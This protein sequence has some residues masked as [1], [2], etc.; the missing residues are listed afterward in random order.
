MPC[1]RAR[2][3]RSHDF[4]PECKNLAG[5]GSQP[6]CNVGDFLLTIP[7][8]SAAARSTASPC[9]ARRTEVVPLHFSLCRTP[10]LVTPVTSS[11][12]IRGAGFLLSRIDG[13]R[14]KVVYVDGNHR[15]GCNLLDWLRAGPPRRRP[16]VTQRYRCLS[17]GTWNQGGTR[18]DEL[19]SPVSSRRGIR[20]L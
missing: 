19:L 3:H 14:E 17:P 20:R 13:S 2:P 9:P 10:S 1:A 6:F 4:R 18:L 12:F 11:P 16:M 7:G 5:I 8:A 15:R